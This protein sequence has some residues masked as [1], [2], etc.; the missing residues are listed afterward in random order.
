MINDTIEPIAKFGDIT[1]GRLNSQYRYSSEL[2]INSSLNP[3]DNGW[4]LT[5]E[6]KGF[7]VSVTEPLTQAIHVEEGLK[8]RASITSK[9][10]KA[11]TKGRVQINWMDKNGKFL[12][13]SI[14]IYDCSA[15]Y[16]EFEMEALPPKNA[17]TAVFYLNS[18]TPIP[19]QI[20]KASLKAIYF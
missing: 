3:G 18:H 14:M 11:M 17:T 16:S 9:C 19:V 12:D 7:Q 2:L 1:V 20:S 6:S 13:T 8:Y 15:Q 4:G 10:S 5:N